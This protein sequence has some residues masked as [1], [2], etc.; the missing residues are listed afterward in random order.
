MG[1]RINQK[2]F[3]LRLA[4][5]LIL[6]PVLM[7]ALAGALLWQ[8]NR[9]LSSEQQITHTHEV[10]AQAYRIE[11]QLVNMESG[12]RGYLITGDSNFLEPYRQALSSIDN[13]FNKLAHLVSD[14]P[15]QLQR[16]AKLRAGRER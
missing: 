13:E 12:V 4:G 14:N 10:I 2:N 7:A 8:I 3:R 5:T 11:K 6:P 16:L 9:I 1:K 15:A